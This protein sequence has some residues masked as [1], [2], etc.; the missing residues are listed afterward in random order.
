MTNRIAL[1]VFLVASLACAYA[2]AAFA[3][4]RGGFG[5]GRIGGPAA[6]LPL[7][8]LD[9]TEAQRQQVQAVRKQYAATLEQAESR[10]REANRAQRA[11]IQTVPVNEG[12]VRSTTQALADAETEVAIEQARVYSDVW[13]L[14][15]P[16]QQ[17]RAKALQAQRQGGER[18]RGGRGPR[19]ARQQP[20]Q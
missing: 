20:P 12:L 2:G 18:G 9:L 5:G 17:S 11:A 8:E 14:L 1:S 7:R 16:E 13:Q 6:D 3:Q 19:P 15:T 10:L 4:G